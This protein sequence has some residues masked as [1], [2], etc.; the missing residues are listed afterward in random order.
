MF[1]QLFSLSIIPYDHS[2]ISLI[3]NDIATIFIAVIQHWDLGILMLVYW[4][5]S[6]IIGVFTVARIL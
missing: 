1:Q 4:F 3:A 2:L 5:Q 6:V